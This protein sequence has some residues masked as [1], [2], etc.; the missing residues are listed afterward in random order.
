MEKKWKI[1]DKNFDN[2][3]NSLISLLTL[4]TFDSWNEFLFVATNS[5]LPEFV[6]KFIFKFRYL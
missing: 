4:S 2:L 5:H 6:F 3:F 1:Y